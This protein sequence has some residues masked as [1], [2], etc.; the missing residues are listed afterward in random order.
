MDQG[1]GE[2]GQDAVMEM[3]DVY[4]GNIRGLCLNVRPGEC[5]VLQDMDNSILEDLR[6]FWRGQGRTRDRS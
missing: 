1:T 6:I 2:T 3:R 5:V 4:Y